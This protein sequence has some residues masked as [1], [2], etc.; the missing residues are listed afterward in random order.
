MTRTGP[1]PVPAPPPA[2][3]PLAPA[4]LRVA[5]V[6]DL[7]ASVPALI[8]FRPRESLVLVGL[9]GPSG[10][11]IRLTLR[12]DLPP[13]DPA[14]VRAVAEQVATGLLAGEPR[15]AVLLVYAAG[16]APVRR[17]LV[18]AV[19]AALGA[20]GVEVHTAVWAE[21]AAAGAAW[22]C[23]DGCCAGVLADP[24]ATAAAATTAAAGQVV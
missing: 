9:G 5:D 6:A 12:V 23:Y 24:S 15:G 14:T 7:V 16:A 13:P 19:D 1:P 22:G 8:G 4:V 11:R 18:A 17:D 3:E 20:R 2:P 10:R 21:R